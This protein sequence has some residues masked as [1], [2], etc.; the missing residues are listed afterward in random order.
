ELDRAVI[1]K[2]FL[3]DGGD[4]PARR[5]RFDRE[6]DALF[7]WHFFDMID[8]AIGNALAPVNQL[9]LGAARHAFEEELTV[10][11]GCFPLQLETVGH[12]LDFLRLI[13]V[14]IA[15]VLYRRCNESMLA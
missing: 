5:R 6:I 15:R 11:R 12:S 4:N 9:D 3:V 2:D 13:L 10:G 14:P 8:A 7:R 1:A